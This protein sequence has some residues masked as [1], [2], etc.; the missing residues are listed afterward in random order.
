MSTIHCGIEVIGITFVCLHKAILRTSSAFV[1]SFTPLNCIVLH[2]SLM[3]YVFRLLQT[4]VLHALI[5]FLS[6]G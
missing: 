6:N 1:S 3:S 4:L 2:I 5:R